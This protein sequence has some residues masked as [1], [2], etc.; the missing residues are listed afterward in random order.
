[1]FSFP[2]IS[3]LMVGIQ[4]VLPE[5]I[6]SGSAATSA[7]LIVYLYLQNKQLILDDL[8]GLQN[9]KTFS[10]MILL[11]IRRRLNMEI[12]L[13]SIDDFKLI[14][15]KFGYLNGD[16]FLKAISRYLTQVVSIKSIY[17]YSGDEFIVIHDKKSLVSV[18][19]MAETI[20]DRF[21]E[22]WTI[23]T[24]RAKLA[25]SI[26]VVKFPDH[27]DTMEAIIALL[28]YCVDLSKRSGKGKIIFSDVE[29]VDKLGR[30]THVIGRMKWG[31][32]H[33]SF[34]VHYQ[35][36]YSTKNDRFTTAE[37]L[38][39]FSDIELGPISLGEL[40]PIAEETGMIVEIGLLVLDKVCKYIQELNE[41]GIE[42]DAI[43]I[44]LSAVQLKSEGFIAK[45]LEIINS[46]HIHPDKLRMEITESVFIE[47][48]EFINDM[49]LQ[50]NEHGIKFYM[51]DF[52]TGY[53]N[54]ASIIN[55]P[56]EFIKIDK[57][58][59]YESII[60]KKCFSVLT[61]FCR[62]FSEVGMK[63]VIEGV[64]NVQ[65]KKI[66]EEV[67]ADYIQGFLFARPLIGSEAIRYLGKSLSEVDS[68]VMASLQAKRILP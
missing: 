16:E 34:N 49:M 55:L 58:I 20:R 21:E 5:I 60:S 62:T 47:N 37:A 2:M 54:M 25:T 10:K 50:L 41:L 46:N 53:S 30:K 23:G 17:R 68:F 14:N 9:R 39:R 64:E 36:I 31:L 8:T 67:K 24:F 7:L 59:L 22:Y 1:L 12:I 13:V 56:F 40:I 66:A 57:S 32:A 26:A 28:E 11:N 4:S 35:P 48:A 45:I 65:Q 52:G 44:N 51:D 15:D 38:L 6:F 43:S 19:D 63:I 42:F 3:L 33:D 27:A 18:A 61:G 29:K